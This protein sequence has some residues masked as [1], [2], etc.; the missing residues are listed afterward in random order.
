MLFSQEPHQTIDISCDTSHYQLNDYLDSLDYYKEKFGTHYKLHTKD[1]KLKLAFFVA[2]S[3]YPELKNTKHH[4]GPTIQRL[5]IQKK[6]KSK[7]QS[8]C[9]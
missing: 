2:L 5:Y 3:H 7:I 9:Q 8:D 4:A 6:R 1:E